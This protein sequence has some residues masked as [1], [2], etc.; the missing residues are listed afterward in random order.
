VQAI[1]FENL[2]F[3]SYKTLVPSLSEDGRDTCDVWK[4]K[5]GHIWRK[6]FEIVTVG[7]GVC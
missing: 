4:E 7:A 6:L 3:K 1:K 5:K 2:W